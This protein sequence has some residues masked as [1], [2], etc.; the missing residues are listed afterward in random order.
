MSNASIASVSQSSKTIKTTAF[1]YPIKQRVK[2]TRKLNQFFKQCR[3]LCFCCRQI[4]FFAKNQMNPPPTAKREMEDFTRT[5]SSC[6][7]ILKAL[8]DGITPYRTSISVYH[9]YKYLAAETPS[10]KQFHKVKTKPLISNEVLHYDANERALFFLYKDMQYDIVDM[11]KTVI[12]CIN[13]DRDR[14][15][16]T[17]RLLQSSVSFIKRLKAISLMGE[18]SLLNEEEFVY[19]ALLPYL[20]SE[21]N[22]TSLIYEFACGYNIGE[23]VKQQITRIMFRSIHRL[24]MG[25]A[26]LCTTVFLDHISLREEKSRIKEIV[27]NFRGVLDI[28]VMKAYLFF[29]ANIDADECCFNLDETRDYDKNESLEYLNKVDLCCNYMDAI[30]ILANC[31][32]VFY[33]YMIT[34]VGYNISNNFFQSWKRPEPMLLE[35]MD[36]LQPPLKFESRSL[37][38]YKEL[39][40]QLIDIPTLTPLVTMLSESGI[41]L[42]YFLTSASK[43]YI[44]NNYLKLKP[45]SIE[46]SRDKNPGIDGGTFYFSNCYDKFIKTD[47]NY[48]KNFLNKSNELNKRKSIIFGA[49]ICTWKNDLV[50]EISSKGFLAR[51]TVVR[52]APYPQTVCFWEDDHEVRAKVLERFSLSFLIRQ[53]N[54]ERK[55]YRPGRVQSAISVRQ[56]LLVKIN[57]Y[58]THHSP[59]RK[60]DRVYL[61]HVL[62]LTCRLFWKKLC[63]INEELLTIVFPVPWL[64]ECVI[65]SINLWLLHHEKEDH[66][67]ISRPLW[68]E[69]EDENSDLDDLP[70]PTSLGL[71]HANPKVLKKE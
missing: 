65:Q 25:L 42:Y 6:M 50:N 61:K 21:F 38:Y 4:W 69:I 16:G 52:I 7:W 40:Q 2:R 11:I 10:M 60:I 37:R 9:D 32:R 1:N 15:M 44:D 23:E 59:P 57:E 13:L 49:I 19:G 36:N 27:I 45:A 34:I 3:K 67:K 41:N 46:L 29:L 5:M 64:D 66:I 12:I 54:A 51:K 20:W 22:Q 30:V 53:D 56:S 47:T 48:V 33:D 63:F 58:F 14:D 35:F 71:I 31:F 70:T 28:L 17:V 26:G 62:V 18:N 68:F 24:T 43:V 55:E 8:V 39:A